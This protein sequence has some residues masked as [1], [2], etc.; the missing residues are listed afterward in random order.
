MDRTK[1]QKLAFG[2]VPEPASCTGGFRLLTKQVSD[3]PAQTAAPHR[4]LPAF[5]SQ[6]RLWAPAS[7]RAATV[8]SET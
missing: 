8:L 4:E 6:S 7:V 3:G 1:K 5:V 2:D